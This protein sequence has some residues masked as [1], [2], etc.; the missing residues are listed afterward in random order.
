M[1]FSWSDDQQ[2]LREGAVKFAQERLNEDVVGRDRRGEFSRDLWQACAEFGAQGMPAPRAYGGGQ[3]EPLDIVAVLEGLGYGCKDNGLLFS[4]GAHLWACEIPFIKFGTEEQKQRYLTRL[5]NGGAVGA[6]GMTEPDSGS[7]AYALRT[8]AVE[9]GDHYVLNGTKIF[10]TNAP[11][12]DVFV[13]Y[14]RTGGKGFAG[15]TCFVV[16]RGTKGLALGQT[17]HKM[18][19]RTS[20][21]AEVVLQ[22]CR[23]PRENVIGRKGSGSMVFNISME[24]ERLFIMATAVGS[25]QQQLERCTEYIKVRKAGH[26]PL[27]KHQVVA[28]KLVDMELRLEQCRL[29]LYRAAWQKGHKGMAMQESAMAKICVSEAYVHNCRDA[30]QLHGAYGYMEEYELERELRDAMA[31]TLYS[32]TSEVQRNIMAGLKGL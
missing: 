14:A 29:V 7:D 25:M 31:C 6:N 18:G 13:I 21:M 1:D 2:Q 5:C 30:I 20:P 24:W 23:V 9:D 4:L 19:L 8:S 26:T 27:S 16:E 22:D 12:A 11:V 32:G 28:H 10:V 3:Y 15:I 17:F